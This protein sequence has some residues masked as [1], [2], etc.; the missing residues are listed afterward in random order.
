MQVLENTIF[1]VGGFVLAIL[2]D[3]A[4][5]EVRFRRELKQN[6]HIDLSGEDWVAAWQTSVK[7][8]EVL[9][10]EELIIAQKGGIVNMRNKAISPENRIAGYMWRGRLQLYQG[11]DLMG[12]Y[13]AEKR[14]NN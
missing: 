6:D 4:K 8:K 10:T 14:E 9:N 13:F 1:T 2:W 3:L 12:H 5:D 7:G 11:R